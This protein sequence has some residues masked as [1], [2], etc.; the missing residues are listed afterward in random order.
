MRGTRRI[1]L[2]VGSYQCVSPNLN[3]VA[4]QQY[5]AEIHVGATAHCD[6]VALQLGRRQ[7]LLSLHVYIRFSHSAI[8]HIFCPIPG[9]PRIVDSKCTHNMQAHRSIS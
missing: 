5:T 7:L 8:V 9:L 2:H 1:K 3:C 6:V 4:I